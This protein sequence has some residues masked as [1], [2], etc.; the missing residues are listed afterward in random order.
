MMQASAAVTARV[1]GVSS[2]SRVGKRFAPL[3]VKPLRTRTVVKASAKSEVRWPH[4]SLSLLLVNTGTSS[5]R[6]VIHLSE[7][8]QFTRR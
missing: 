1:A 6:R 5:R 3:P 2:A 8:L 7:I 4:L